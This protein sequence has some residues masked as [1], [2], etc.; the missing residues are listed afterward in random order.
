MDRDQE[1]IELRKA[2]TREIQARLKARSRGDQI[3]KLDPDLPHFR[4]LPVSD[5]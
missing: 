1:D 3:V 2:E 4:R 5:F